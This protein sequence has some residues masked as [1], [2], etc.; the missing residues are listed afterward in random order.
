M[1]RNKKVKQ[2]SRNLYILSHPSDITFCTNRH[3]MKLYELAGV[4][5][6]QA[7]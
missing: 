7:Y 1:G 5:M 4:A 3:H 2:I 6:M